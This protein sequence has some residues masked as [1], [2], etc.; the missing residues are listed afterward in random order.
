MQV[1]LY[2][3]RAWNGFQFLQILVLLV[4]TKLLTVCYVLYLL[5]INTLDNI[6]V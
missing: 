6:Q 5:E 1:G 2:Y 3:L 4:N